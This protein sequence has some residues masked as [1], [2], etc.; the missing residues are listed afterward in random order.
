MG[1]RSPPA[2]PVEPRAARRRRGR[3]HGGDR[4]PARVW[5]RDCCAI[6]RGRAPAD[7]HQPRGAAPAS[8]RHRRAPRRERAARM[9]GRAD[10]GRRTRRGRGGARAAARVRR[11]GGAG[12]H[13]PP[14]QGPRVPGRV[15]PVPVGP[16]VDPHAGAGLLPRP[17]AGQPAHDRR[18]P[19]GAQM[20][21]SLRPGADRAARRGPAPGLRRAD[22]RPAS[23]GD[24]VG[25]LPGQPELGAGAPAF[26]RDEDGNV[27]ADG[28]AEP[29]T[30]AAADARFQALAAEAPGRISVE[31]ASAG[32]PVAWSPPLPQPPELRTARFDRQLDLRWRRTSYSDITAEA[33]D[34][35]VASEPERPMLDDEPAGATPTG[36][37][38]EP[39]RSRGPTDRRRWG[40]C[41]RA[42]SSGRS[43]TACWRPRTSRR[44]TSRPS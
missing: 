24:L 20:A 8:C 37:G 36:P 40:R 13:H 43:C 16:D 26:D 6:E 1:G 7:R 27:A 35:L 25:A 21:G 23:G 42:S 30:D 38:P 34:P 22:A 28:S 5:R 17:R 44:T 15:L 33:H 32:A 19:R 14:Q 39:A 3:P 31:R 12:A 11:R 41:R 10:V 2:A 29:P 4:P 18:R 9:A